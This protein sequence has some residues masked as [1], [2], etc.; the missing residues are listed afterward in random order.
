MS[1]YVF[2]LMVA[3]TL[4]SISSAHAEGL[5]IAKPSDVSMSPDKLAEV[6]EAMQKSIDDNRI[7]GGIV[8]IAKD[9]KVVMHQAYG[10]MDIDADKPMKPDTIVRIYSMT[11]AITTAAAMM[12]Y[13]EGKLDVNDPV[14]KYLPELA[15]VTV[16]SDSEVRPAENTMTIAD[17]M[18]HTAGYSYGRGGKT[19]VDNAFEN[20]N[21]LDR[22]ASLATMQTKLDDL[23]LEFEPGTD[24]LY[25][26]SIDVLGRVVE[27]VSGQPLDTFFQ[28]RFFDPLQMVD[29]GFYVP[30]QKTDRFAVNYQSDGKGKLTSK[31][32]EEENQYLE[33]PALLSGGGGLVS[34]A[35]DY[36]KFLIMIE[37]GGELNGTRLL[38]PETVAMMTTN[39]LPKDVGWIKFGSEVRTGVGF[40]FGFNVRDEMSDWDPDGRVGEYGW[41]GA[42]STHYWISPSDR[43]IV[44]T[45][46]QVMPYQWL[47]ELKLKGL[48]YDAIED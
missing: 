31:E 6:S 10:K 26:I 17:L 2:S 35:A 37:A 5:P 28:T 29:T 15:E 19:A 38:K 45:M 32:E 7:A 41:G 36:M 16:A 23:P 24:W 11:K 14:S 25:G 9:G 20:L 39:Q 27:V 3:F 48:I 33:K 43:L 22:E 46:E 4:H 47:T 8:M 18:R 42:A 30:P 34:T 40:G 1:R 13:E 21:A 12:L 44:I